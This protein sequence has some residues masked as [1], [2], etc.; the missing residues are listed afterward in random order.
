[1]NLLQLVQRACVEAEYASAPATVVSQT[2]QFA[3]MVNWVIAADQEIQNKYQRWNFLLNDVSF[4]T[5][6]LT[7]SYTPTA[8]GYPELATWNPETFRRWLTSTGSAN[9]ID[10]TYY[11]WELFRDLYIFGPLRSQNGPPQF[12]TIKPDKSLMFWP[13]PDNVYTVVGEYWKRAQVMSA[14]SDEPLYPSQFHLAPVWKALM[15]YG[16]SQAAPE[17]YTRGAMEFKKLMEDLEIDQ[18]PE[19]ELGET[20]T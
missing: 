19:M 6:A 1:M 17:A 9:E 10:L 5:V 13:T 18:L 12:F 11:P 20:L 4:P 14:N 15:S 2:G 8:A 16:S 7:Q 3:R